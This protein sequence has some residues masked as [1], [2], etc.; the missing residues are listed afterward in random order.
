MVIQNG[1]DFAASNRSYEQFVIGHPELKGI[2]NISE[3]GANEATVSCEATIQSSPVASQ[4]LRD[5]QLPPVVALRATLRRAGSEWQVAD[6]VLLPC[7]AVQL[8]GPS[9]PSLPIILGRLVTVLHAA[10]CSSGKP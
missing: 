4:I 10:L 7:H 8:L 9:N 2:T 3:N 6:T 5:Q 1:S